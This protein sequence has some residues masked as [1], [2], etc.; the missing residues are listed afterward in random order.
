MV[1]S[2]LLKSSWLANSNSL[3]QIFTL[4][5]FPYGTLKPELLFTLYNPLKHVWFKNMKY[6]AKVK[7]LAFLALYSCR[8]E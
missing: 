8:I 2:N 5:F 1:I 3:L 4:E 6:D 7:L